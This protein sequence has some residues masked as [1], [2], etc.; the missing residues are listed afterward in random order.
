MQDR[1]LNFGFGTLVVALLAAATG[2]SLQ[3]REV[4]SPASELP[5]VEQVTAAPPTVDAPQ[6]DDSIVT[7]T[8]LLENFF[9]DSIQRLRPCADR[10]SCYDLDF[11]IVALPDPLDSFLDWAFDADLE[12]MRRAFENAQYVTNRFWLPWDED[13]R[14]VPGKPGTRYRWNHP[15]VFLLRNSNPTRHRLR[16]VYVVGEISTG[17]VHKR[18]LEA[19]LDERRTLLDRRIFA[20][21][22]GARDTIRLVAP[23]FTGSALSTRL[24]LERWQDSTKDSSFALFVSGAATGIGNLAV[25]DSGHA[26]ATRMPR[27]SFRATVNSDVTLTLAMLRVMVDSLEGLGIPPEHIA[28]IQESSTQYGQQAASR[29]AS[30]D[31]LATSTGRARIDSSRFSTMLAPWNAKIQPATD[32]MLVIYYPMSISSLRSEYAKHPAVPNGADE[33]R[34]DPAPRIPLPLY[35]SNQQLESPIPVAQLTPASLDLMIDEIAQTLKSHNIRAIGL[36]GTDVRDK[37]FLADQLRKRLPD[38]R[39]FTFGSNNLYLRD[40]YNGSL[41]GMIV[42][43]TYPLFPENQWWDMVHRARPGRLVFPSDDAQG[44]FNATLRQITRRQF[45][46]YRAPFDST[47]VYPPVWVTAVGRHSFIPVR[48]FRSLEGANEY[49]EKRPPPASLARTV[50]E[51]H[52]SNSDRVRWLMYIAAAGA[53]L[54]LVLRDDAESRVRVPIH[55]PAPPPIGTSSTTNPITTQET[56]TEERAI[57]RFVDRRRLGLRAALLLHREIYAFLRH[58][59]L[60]CVFAAIAVIVVPEAAEYEQ[61]WW[62]SPVVYSLLPL[63]A[64]AALIAFGAHVR[65]VWLE[66]GGAYRDYVYRPPHKWME[67]E[68]ARTRRLLARLEMNQPLKMLAM[69]TPTVEYEIRALAPRAERSVWRREGIV[70]AI[71]AMVGMLYAAAVAKL[72]VDLHRLDVS[73]AT[74]FVHRATQLDS[75]VSPIFPIVLS[76]AALAI[77]CTWQLS[78][79]TLLDE[80]TAFEEAFQLSPTRVAQTD[81]EEIKSRIAKGLHAARMHLSRVVPDLP[82]GVSKLL[83][84]LFVVALALALWIHFEPSFEAITGLRRTGRWTAFD[85]VFRLSILMIFAASSWALARLVMVWRALRTTLR[86][87]DASPLITAF[88]R[89]PR[90]ISRLTRL[91]LFADPSR[92]TVLAVTATQWM[93]LRSLFVANEQSF[94]LVGA[95]AAADVRHLLEADAPLYGRNHRR[96]GVTFAPQLKEMLCLM[97]RFWA[98]EPAVTQV[99]AVLAELK[100]QAQIEGASTSGRIRR[101][102]PDVVRLWVRSAEEFV[103]VQAVDYIGWVIRHLRR[104]VLM[105]LFLLV[106]TMALLSSYSF[107]PQSVV[108][109]LFLL[110]FLAVVVSLLLVLSQMNRDE[111]LSRVTRTDPG[112]LNWS[113]GFLFNVGTVVAIPILSLLSAFSPLRTDLFG[114]IDIILRSISKH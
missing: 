43:S 72:V 113:A 66:W 34:R 44:V 95:N 74:L 51:D 42:F 37:I 54:F 33:F 84:G 60:F 77:L 67:R 46:E 2:R 63:M 21:S 101:C 79:L 16:L 112:R 110:L 5:A 107:L 93:H 82:S 48:A 3:S 29:S 73:D 9:G 40:D 61:L 22:T 97:E 13:R 17:G 35:D 108:R 26:A 83:T 39:L 62:V 53:V 56:S 76:S 1:A 24:T 4:Q 50:P 75:G 20:D 90:R 32:K 104:L 45:R 59:A 91:T 27:M 38:A 81:V 114:W 28:L 25:F 64:L 103:A 105:L 30:P 78:R 65:E 36:I 106:V 96:A 94:E 15:G 99:E 14:V 6:Q 58:L 11:V 68:I 102:F 57:R 69:L 89:L 52:V 18:A 31:T 41:R 8:A 86:A 23:F 7:G 98:T 87:L 10:S 85:V 55:E 109:S 19:A 12:S 111:V 100:A 71:T 88:E 70:I 92:E 80:V 49:L 47:G